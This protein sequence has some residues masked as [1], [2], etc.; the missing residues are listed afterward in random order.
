MEEVGGEEE[1]E[2][3]REGMNCISSNQKAPSLWMEARVRED[4]VKVLLL[5]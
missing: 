5:L 2:R 4:G 3:E 1:R